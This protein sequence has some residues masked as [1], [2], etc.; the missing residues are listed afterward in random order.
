[1][2]KS[3]PITTKGGVWQRLLDAMA[4]NAGKTVSNEELIKVSGQH[5]YARRVRELRAEGWDIVYSPSPMG[6]TLRSLVKSDKDTDVY[7]NLKLRQKVLERDQYTCQLCG[8]R[9]GEK[10]A[11]GEIVRLEVDHITPLKQEGKT[12]EENLWTLCSRCNAGKK[13][14]FDYPE[15]VKNKILSVNLSE[16]TRKKLSELSLKSGRTINDLVVEAIDR[17]V[18]KLK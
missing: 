11:D 3:K 8:H 14:L 4:K 12:V 16:E 9:G 18:E 5:N 13:S 10:Y 17:G 6:Y 1:M 15:T 7:I 2:K